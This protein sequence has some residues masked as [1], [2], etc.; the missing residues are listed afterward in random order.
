MVVFSIWRRTCGEKSQPIT[1]ITKITVQ[2]N[3]TL[4]N[5][6]TTQTFVVLSES[7]RRIDTELRRRVQTPDPSGRRDTYVRKRRQNSNESTAIHRAESQRLHDLWRRPSSDRKSGA[8]PG[9]S[10]PKRGRPSSR[11]ATHQ[12][13]V[14]QRA[15]RHRPFQTDDAQPRAGRPA[16]SRQTSTLVRHEREATAREKP[17]KLIQGRRRTPRADSSPPSRSVRG[18]RGCP[19]L[20]HARGLATRAATG[21]TDASGLTPALRSI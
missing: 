5:P 16:W 11:S 8:R 6:L 9:G 4:Q 12:S 1:E 2:R 13:C 21:T 14:A 19:P 20:F 10:V 15:S 7:D 18:Y 17:E 3:I